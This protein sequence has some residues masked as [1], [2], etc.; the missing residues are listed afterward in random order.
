[1]TRDDIQPANYE[2]RAKSRR[3]IADRKFAIGHRSGSS[4]GSENLR[5]RLEIVK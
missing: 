1:M 2:Q 5:D 3:F 4:V